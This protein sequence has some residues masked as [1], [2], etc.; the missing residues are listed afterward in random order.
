MLDTGATHVISAI[1][2]PLRNRYEDLAPRIRIEVSDDGVEWR[3]RWFGWTGWLAMAATLEDPR[4][5]P[6]RMPLTPTAARYVRIH[7]APDWLRDEVR[8]LAVR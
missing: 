4:H 2:F 3:E 7:P 5:A 8:V 6:V 1:E